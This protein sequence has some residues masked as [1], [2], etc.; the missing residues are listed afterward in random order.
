MKVLLTGSIGVGKTTLFNSIHD[1]PGIIKIPEVARRV[2]S[3]APDLRLNPYFQR[4]LL[5]EQYFLEREVEKSGA[6]LIVCDRGYFDVLAYSKFF[7]IEVDRQLINAFTS[8]DFIFY[9]HPEGTP[10]LPQG[11]PGVAP[12]EK[13]KELVDQSIRQVLGEMNIPWHTLKGPTP[14]RLSEFYQKIDE[15]GEGKIM[16]R[17]REIRKEAR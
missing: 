8:Y 12:T 6:Q 17:R 9:C 2:L 3:D 1:G 14:E 11:I 7:R 10:P 13:E 4:V 15:T 16:I 5:L